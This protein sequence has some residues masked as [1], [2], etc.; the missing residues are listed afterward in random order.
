MNVHLS[1]VLESID[2]LILLGMLVSFRNHRLA[3]SAIFNAL[4][5]LLSLTMDAFLVYMAIVNRLRQV[6][7]LY[8]RVLRV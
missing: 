3:G 5:V 7:E 8:P 2:K 6:T 1:D 4:D